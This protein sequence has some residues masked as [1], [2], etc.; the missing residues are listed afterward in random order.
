[1]STASQFQPIL[2]RDYLDGERQ[3]KRKHEYVNGVVYAMAG[4]TVQHSRIASNATGVLFTQ[5][6][7]Q[8][9]QVFNSDMKIRV[10]QS[11][12]TRFYYPD[13]SVV[14]QPNKAN[15]SF[16][17]APVVIVE[18]ISESTRRTDEYEK[19]EAYL[20]IDSLGTYILVEQTSASALVYR[21][22]DSGF[23]REVYTGLDAIIPLPEIQ[24][25]L[26]L[27]EI[28]QNVEFVPIVS[29][30]DEDGA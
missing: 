24:C 27:G 2:V 15:D 18:V 1:M 19:R 25:K 10:R 5:L 3:A 13:V 9:C 17:D 26:S 21:R 20:T 14:C 29:D 8:R 30:D 16:Q 11:S 22:A 7:G 6:R 28:Y 4:G 12:G 23:D